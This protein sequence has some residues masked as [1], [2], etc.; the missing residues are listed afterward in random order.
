MESLSFSTISGPK[1]S[2]TFISVFI[3]VRRFLALI[4]DCCLIKKADTLSPSSCSC[5]LPLILTPSRIS[6]L[7]H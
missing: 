5:I 4:L 6:F 3:E 2:I 7:D 1:L